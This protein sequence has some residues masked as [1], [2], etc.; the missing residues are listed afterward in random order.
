MP[1]LTALLEDDDASVRFSAAIALGRMSVSD[2]VVLNTLDDAMQ[3]GSMETKRYAAD[4]LGGVG[5]AAEP[6]LI[7]ALNAPDPFVR[8]NA[9]RSLGKI[10]AKE[11]ALAIPVLLELI[12]APSG[13]GIVAASSFGELGSAET[14]AVPELVA[15]FNRG[16]GASPARTPHVPSAKSVPRP[17]RLL[18]NSLKSK[19]PRTMPMAVT[20][21]TAASRNVSLPKPL[22]RLVGTRNQRCQYLETQ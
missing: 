6:I 8:I 19:G 16:R 20:I 12:E 5:L 3:N 7:E 15:I 4:A 2:E 9:S 13:L 17:C 11:K 10:D 1:A 18:S 22:A 21:S 14:E